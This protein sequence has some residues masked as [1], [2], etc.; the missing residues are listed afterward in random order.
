MR[1][2]ESDR[3]LTIF[4]NQWLGIVIINR[5]SS[6]SYANR[7]AEG[8]LE[9]SPGSLPGM[10]IPDLSPVIRNSLMKH[11]EQVMNDHFPVRFETMTRQDKRLRFSLYPD[12]QDVIVTIE[13][14]TIEWMVGE[15][16]RL[17]L[18][19]MNNLPYAMFIVRFTG[20]IINVNDLAT[21]F[22]GYSQ[23]ELLKMG[24]I[25]V[26]PGLDFGAERGRGGM[27]PDKVIRMIRESEMLRKDGGKVP[28]EV[29]V[30]E[31]MLHGTRQYLM[32]VRDITERKRA[33]EE[34]S[35]LAAIVTS[36][37][38]AIIGKSLDGTI[39][40]WN[41]GAEQ[42]FGYTAAEAVGESIGIIYPSDRLQE[43]ENILKKIGRGE[44][45]D[46]YETV[47]RGKDGR[48][49]DVSITI[50]PILD[51]TGAVV[52]AST[53]A[54]DITERK[55]AEE[56]LK[57]AK[58]Q[59][60]LYLDLMGHDIS[61]MHQIIL[62]RLQL[63]EEI[64]GADGKLEGDDKEL[65][66]VSISNLKRSA[67]LIDNVKKLQKLRWGEYNRGPVDLGQ[68]LDDVVAAYS[69][70][71]D[72][73]VIISY[74][75]AQGHVVSVNPLIKEVFNNLVD[76]A[77]KYSGDPVQIG[78]SVD[79]VDRNGRSY[80]RVAIEDNGPGIPDEKKREVFHR[81]SR[82]QTKA[83]GTGLGLYIVKTLV[84]SF[85]GIVE[86]ADRV[87]GDYTQGSRFLVY[88]PVVEGDVNGE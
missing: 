41:K 57:T 5:A 29:S 44:G 67:R 68:V 17:A 31:K 34:V 48:R 53:I 35:R 83:R 24:I 19:T 46:H 56:E 16:A 4:E 60:E 50:S 51:G 78:I 72:K 54:R 11:Y 85:D 79:Q 27:G 7:A 87:E 8:L 59:A 64:I 10:R 69:C 12:E 33:E 81:L 25:K 26:L 75:R 21:D 66:D 15:A 62:A 32:I 65:I 3:P 88:L 74:T 2:R 43:L 22:T 77:V 38:D 20:Q 9:M 18:M 61:N 30:S 76:N 52:G 45:V 84:E 42:L 73:K 40:T 58:E 70:V 71:P 23:E 1:E 49:I 37:N 86:V 28:V 55:R 63:A 47:R 6:V 13:D 39:T 36:S 14:N 82:G 80:H